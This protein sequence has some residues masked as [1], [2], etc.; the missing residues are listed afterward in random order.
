VTGSEFIGVSDPMG[1]WNW[2]ELENYQNR[3]NLVLVLDHGGRAGSNFFQCLFDNHSSFVVSPLIH[4]VYSS[5][6]RVFGDARMV[7]SKEAHRFVSALSYSR[8]LYQEPVGDIGKI[9]YK[10]GGDPAAPFDRV[11]FRELIDA[12]FER[13]ETVT[14]KEAILWTYAAYALVRGFSL[15]EITLIGINDAV[16]L[17]SEDMLSGFAGCIIDYAADDFPDLINLALVRDPRAQFASTRHQMVNEFGNNYMI[18]FGNWWA[19]F[20][21]LWKDNFSLEH[22][23][24]HFCS[25]YQYAAFIALVRKWQENRGS[26]YFIR[27]EDINTNFV[28]TMMSLCD[29]LGIQPDRA[30]LSDNNYTVTMLGRP[31]AGTGAYSNR[32]QEV[33]DGPIPNDSDDVSA[34]AI[35]PNRYVTE[36]W[37]SRIP[38]C[39]KLL[40]DSLFYEEISVFEYEFSSDLINQPE[41]LPVAA[42]WS[43]YAGEVPNTNWLLKP[44]KV[45]ERLFY[46]VSFMPFYGLARIKLMKLYNRNRFFSQFDFMDIFKKKAVFVRGGKKFD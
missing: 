38:A 31:W 15:D 7:D 29:L 41:K 22:G 4:Y 17:A 2:D 45:F 43:A 13:Q 33:G 8:L 11:K 44:N 36:R 6:V 25:V 1:G 35:G 42:V 14:R 27:N 28:S 40:L 37:K 23:P 3:V 12:V 10:I 24:A 9:I 16:S 39:E 20:S 30:W 46:L 18:S 19:A 32:Y 5:W 21:K 26:W 34:K